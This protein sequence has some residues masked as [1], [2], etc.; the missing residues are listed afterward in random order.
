ME[1]FIQ[2]QEYENGI[3]GVTKDVKKAFELYQKASGLG[4][5]KATIKVTNNVPQE[6]GF[7]R[8]AED[9]LE[10]ADLQEFAGVIIRQFLST[11]G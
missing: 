2:G 3:G 10:K 9:L 5:R 6:Q 1:A 7:I 11:C 8:E 4:Y